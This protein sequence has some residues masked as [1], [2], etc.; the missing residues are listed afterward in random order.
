MDYC[1]LLCMSGR[2]VLWWAQNEGPA[3]RLQRLQRL[4]RLT[5]DGNG[6]MVLRVVSWNMDR[7][8]GRRGLKPAIMGGK[9]FGV[10]S[11]RKKSAAGAGQ[12]DKTGSKNQLR[13]A[14]ADYYCC[15]LLLVVVCRLRLA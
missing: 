14:V 11:E 5:G 10:T 1:V 7:R 6:V 13:V 2:Q 15:Q 9:G 4:Q 3:S 8:A 12:N